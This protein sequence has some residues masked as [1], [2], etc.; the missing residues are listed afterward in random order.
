MGDTRMGDTEMGD[1]VSYEYT[2]MDGG[3]N[4]M[5]TGISARNVKWYKARF[6]S[7]IFYCCGAPNHGL[8]CGW[9]HIVFCEAKSFRGK[10]HRKDSGGCY[11]GNL[12][13]ASVEALIFL[14][15]RKQN[16]FFLIWKNYTYSYEEICFLSFLTVRQSLNW[17]EL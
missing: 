16:I 11:N 4:R 10:W 9:E 6:F 17:M 14:S 3:W 13:G 12:K 5:L 1:P 2:Y 7:K 8:T 15:S